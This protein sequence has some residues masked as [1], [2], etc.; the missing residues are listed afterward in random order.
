MWLW[1]GHIDKKKFQTYQKYICKK[2]L[3]CKKNF[4]NGKTILKLWNNLFNDF[5]IRKCQHYFS[6]SIFNLKKSIC[7]KKFTGHLLDVC[8]TSAKKITWWTLSC[9]LFCLQASARVCWMGKKYVHTC[10]HVRTYSP[11]FCFPDACLAI[12]NS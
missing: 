1:I 2:S 9:N 5:V 4:E 8:P 3:N 11:S 12:A 10:M 6:Y 7:C